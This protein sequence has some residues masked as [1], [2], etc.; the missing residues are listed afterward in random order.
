MSISVCVCFLQVGNTDVPTI[1]KRPRKA[2]LCIVSFADVIN[3]YENPFNQ[4][5]EIKDE[6]EYEKDF[7]E[8][9]EC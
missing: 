9:Q 1:P 8:R 4:S 5:G 2:K 6:L 3:N 7:G